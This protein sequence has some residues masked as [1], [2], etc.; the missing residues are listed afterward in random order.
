MCAFTQRREIIFEKKNYLEIL[1]TFKVFETF[2]IPLD[3]ILFSF[4][5]I[6]NLESLLSTL[7]LI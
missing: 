6:S 3:Y 5:E 1:K 2:L 7:L 4:S